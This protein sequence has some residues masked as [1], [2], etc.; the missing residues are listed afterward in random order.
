MPINNNNNG[1]DYRG[2]AVGAL[3]ERQRILFGVQRR[4]EFAF[5]V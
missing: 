1:D 2:R 3:D 5:L 4:H